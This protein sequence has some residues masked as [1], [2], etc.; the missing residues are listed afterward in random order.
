MVN[1]VFSFVALVLVMLF[2]GSPF[3][4]TIIQALY[5][6][7]TLFFFS[8]GVGLFWRPLRC[9]SGISCISGACSSRRFLYF[10]AIFYDPAQMTFMLGGFNMQQII[11][12]NPIYWYITGFRRTLM[13]GIPLDGNMILVCGGCAVVSMAV[14]CTCSAGCRTALC[15]HYGR[16]TMEPIIKVDNVS[17][18]FNLSTEKH[19]SLKGI[20]AGHGAGTA[21]VRRILCAAGREPADHARRFY[22]LVGLNGSGKST[23]LKTIAGVYKPQRAG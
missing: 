9:S 6:L 11:A 16:G 7:I 17:M 21:E 22:G 20:P 8:L 19:E 23:L 14:G 10:S 12:L 2:T 3:H 18:C 5:P 1:C 4:L 15:C 13:W